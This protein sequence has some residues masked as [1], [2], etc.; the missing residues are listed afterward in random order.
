MLTENTRRRALK[1]PKE[2]STL[3]PSS[4]VAFEIELFIRRS[5]AILERAICSRVGIGDSVSV[6]GGDDDGGALDS[7]IRI[8]P[9]LM[10]E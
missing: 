4:T 2:A 5:R 10:R 9:K 3:S 1:R 7:T 8:R 6:S